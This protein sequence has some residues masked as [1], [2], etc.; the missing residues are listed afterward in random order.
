[1][2]GYTYT[3]VTVEIP[4]DCDMYKLC[5]QFAKDNSNIEFL[6]T[7][8]KVIKMALERGCFNHMKKNL[9]F[10]KG[11]ADTYREK[12]KAKVE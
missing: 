7:T 9:D 8:E 1:M 12:K 3:T 4:N 11:Q 6:N 5:E 10:F 2:D